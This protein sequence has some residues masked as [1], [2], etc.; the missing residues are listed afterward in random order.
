[1]KKM[2]NTSMPGLDK[3]PSWLWLAL[4]AAASP[5]FAYFLYN[6]EHLRALLGSL[7]VGVVISLAV[8]MRDDIHTLLYWVIIAACAALHVVLVRSIT[9][10]WR[11]FPGT[12][13]LPVAVLD[14]LVW[15]WMF[16]SAGKALNGSTSRSG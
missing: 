7:S 16:A 15:Q 3:Y 1:M 4:I 13:F 12:I 5:V 14:L 10:E 2:T 11:N 8:T 6:G 9:L